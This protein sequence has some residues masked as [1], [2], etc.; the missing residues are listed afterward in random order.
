MEQ[1]MKS[2]VFL[3]FTLQLSSA[4][5]HSLQYFYTTVTKGINF[6]EFTTVGLVDGG[7]FMYYDSD[8]SNAVAKT[9]WIKKVVGDDPDYWNRQTQGLQG[10]QEIF[11]ANV[12]TAMQRFNQTEGVHTIQVMYGCELHDDGTIRGYRQEG[13]DGE[14]FISLDLNTLTWTAANQKAFI[15]KLKWDSDV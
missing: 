15:T 10:D 13:Y 8:T 1:I 11:K 14:D 9:E 2:L 12:A 3:A 4:A 6:P 7:Q 5:T